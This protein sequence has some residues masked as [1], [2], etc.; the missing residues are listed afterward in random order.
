MLFLLFF[1]LLNIVRHSPIIIVSAI[2]A[3]HS[4]PYGGG[5]GGG[6]FWG[7]GFVGIGFVGLCWALSYLEHKRSDEVVADDTS[8]IAHE[9]NPCYLLHVPSEGYLLQAHNHNASCATY[10]EH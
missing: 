8:E 6:A 1:L 5:A 2:P 10:D 9:S 4:P 7:W 3:Y